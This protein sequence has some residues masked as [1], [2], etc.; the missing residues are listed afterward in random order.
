VVAGWPISKVG[1]L[2][3]ASGTGLTTLSVNPTTIGDC[4][5]FGPTHGQ[6]GSTITSVSGGHCASWTRIAGPVVA[7]GYVATIPELWVGV[8]NAIGSAA[9][10]TIAGA[11]LGPGSQRLVAQQ[12]TTGQGAAS[13]W[14][15]DGSPSN[16]EQDST[17]SATVVWPTLTPTGTNRMYFGRGTVSS[18]ANTTGQTAGYTVALDA[19]SNPFFYNPSVTG[20][21]SPTCTQATANRYTIT[22]V[23]IYSPAPDTAAP[24]KF[25]PFFRAPGHHEDELEQRPSG[26]YVQR[27]RPR[28]FGYRA[29]RTLVKAGR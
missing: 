7:T 18:T 1:S 16:F 22:A 26:L 24:G 8:C 27:N 6:T 11:N 25:L 9:N 14:I 23:L 20:V 3:T 13:T 19:G 21:Q 15:A 2:Y 28:V 10:I 29:P 12:F 5:I 4:L 17:A